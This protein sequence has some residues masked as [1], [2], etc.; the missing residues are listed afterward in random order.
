MKMEDCPSSQ[1]CSAPLCPLDENYAIWYPDEPVCR[2]RGF[3]EHWLK[4]QKRIAKR[5]HNANAG[6]FTVAMLKTMTAVSPKTKGIGPDSHQSEDIWVG[7]R[8]KKTM[9]A[10]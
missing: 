5:V 8:T 6:Y 1:G 2:R 7:K 4:I 9:A 3:K 10:V